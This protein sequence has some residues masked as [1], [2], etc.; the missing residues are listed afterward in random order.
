MNSLKI[1]S[2]RQLALAM[3]VSHGT[4][5]RWSCEG[6]KPHSDGTYNVDDAK[7]YHAPRVLRV[8]GAD[9][10]LRIKQRKLLAEAKF[11][12]LRLD[13]ARGKLV[14]RDAVLREWSR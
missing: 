7:T 14:R 4:A 1:T 3:G 11:V 8:R 9:E 10:A 2:L 6:L 13:E 12:E 5:Q